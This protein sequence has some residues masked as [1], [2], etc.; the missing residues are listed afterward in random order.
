MGCSI[1]GSLATLKYHYPYRRFAYCV[2]LNLSSLSFGFKA[3][4]ADLCVKQRL[5]GSL[6]GAAHPLNDNMGV[7]SVSQ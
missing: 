3:L 7:Q 4:F 6:A 5:T 1:S 2:T